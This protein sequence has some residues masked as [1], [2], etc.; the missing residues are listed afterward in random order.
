MQMEGVRMHCDAGRKIDIMGH[1][2]ERKGFRGKPFV[3]Q[4]QNEEINQEKE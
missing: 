4:V 3:L 2:G 1:F